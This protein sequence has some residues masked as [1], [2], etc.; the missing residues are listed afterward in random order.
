MKHIRKYNEEYGTFGLGNQRLENEK[1]KF[2]SK[3]TKQFGERSIQE[4]IMVEGLYNLEFMVGDQSRFLGAL[5][6][7]LILE[8]VLEGRGGKFD[9]ENKEKKFLFIKYKEKE[10]YKQHIVRLTNEHLKKTG[11]IK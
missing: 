8:G 1:S 7:L 4:D 2:L 11:L 10:T 6:A 3:F 9:Y 5:E